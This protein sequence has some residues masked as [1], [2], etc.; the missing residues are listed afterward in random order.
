MD[1]N[2]GWPYW[3]VKNGIR[4]A[5]PRLAAPV[6]CDVLVVGAGITGALIGYHL[7]RAGMQVCVIGPRGGVRA[8]TDQ[9]VPIRCKHVVRA[10]GCSASTA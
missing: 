3:L 10:P 9:D 5:F 8:A 1:L 7:A 6:T 4:R 2:S